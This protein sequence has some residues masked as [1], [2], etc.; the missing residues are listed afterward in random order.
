MTTRTNQ[1]ARD[2][3]SERAEMMR[4]LVLASSFGLW[5]V[6]LG[7]TP[8]L[9]SRMLIGKPRGNSRPPWLIRASTCGQMRAILRAA[10]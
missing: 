7:L 1:N 8:V 10:F 6:P 2:P 3:I 5:A 9:A 4:N